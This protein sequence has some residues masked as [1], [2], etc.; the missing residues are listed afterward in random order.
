MLPLS[1]TIISFIKKIREKYIFSDSI[2]LNSQYYIF[3][4]RFCNTTCKSFYYVPFLFSFSKKFFFFLFSFSSMDR[5]LFNVL[6]TE[7][8]KW[9]TFLK[10]WA[11]HGKHREKGLLR[12]KCGMKDK[13]S[14]TVQ[15]EFVKIIIRLFDCE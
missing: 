9:M 1:V 3:Y 5:Y 2:L 6:S 10:C 15:F 13:I 8:G 14:F 4:V 11:V 7:D 12:L